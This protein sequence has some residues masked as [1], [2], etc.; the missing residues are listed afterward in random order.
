MRQWWANNRRS[1]ANDVSSAV[2]NGLR[3]FSP[4]APL[5][6]QHLLL[7]ALWATTTTTTRIFVVI[8]VGGVATSLHILLVRVVRLDGVDVG[9]Y[10]DL[11]F[12]VKQQYQPS[13]C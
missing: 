7:L 9:H 1:A 12:L 8:V 5:Y 4:L 11:D 2:G 3:E 10:V 13:P 6:Q